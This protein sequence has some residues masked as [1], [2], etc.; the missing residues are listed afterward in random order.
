MLIELI[1]QLFVLM[2]QATAQAAAGDW[3]YIQT[4]NKASNISTE[5][6]TAIQDKIYAA[7]WH[8]REYERLLMH[9]HTRELKAEIK[10]LIT[11]YCMHVR[12]Y[13]DMLRH[14]QVHGAHGWDWDA[15]LRDVSYQAHCEAHPVQEKAKPHKSR[16]GEQDQYEA[17]YPTYKRPYPKTDRP[18]GWAGQKH[19]HRW[20]KCTRDHRIGAA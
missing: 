20:V 10:A 11:E 15:E 2:A 7:Q 5:I 4:Q 1:A 6:V 17:Y 16:W 3:T 9:A 8:I 13:T 12:R 14:Y 19:G 18:H